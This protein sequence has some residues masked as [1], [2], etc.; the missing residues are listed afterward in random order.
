CFDS[1]EN[2]R[3]DHAV[4]RV[5]VQRGVNVARIGGIYAIAERDL[6]VDHLQIVR[7]GLF[8][9]LD[10]LH[11]NVDWLDRLENR[12]NKMAAR[13][14][15]PTGYGA[16]AQNNAAISRVNRDERQKNE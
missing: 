9:G 12:K 15:R 11:L 8:I 4:L 13:F 16:E 6:R 1:F 7:S 2:R 14:E 5:V 3:D 10:D